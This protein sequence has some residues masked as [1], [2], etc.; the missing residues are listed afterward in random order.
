MIKTSPGCL[1]LVCLLAA[2]AQGQPP[3]PQVTTAHAQGTAAHPAVIKKI[4]YQED[5]KDLSF[6]LIVLPDAV[7]ANKINAALQGS[8][9][10]QDEEVKPHK[11]PF[12]KARL[13]SERGSTD[14]LDYTVLINSDR[15]EE[16]TSELQS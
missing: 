12:D 6:P 13:A 3:H 10:T 16:H 14:E 1:V 8:L 4:V 9:L 5:Q 2:Q 15:S 7:A 11:R